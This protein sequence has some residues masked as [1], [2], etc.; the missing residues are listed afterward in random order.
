[1]RFDFGGRL[2]LALRMG[3]LFMVALGI[4]AACVL[5]RIS[6][7]IWAVPLFV[8]YIGGFVFVF[9][10]G[11]RIVVAA[12]AS[13]TIEGSHELPNDGQPEH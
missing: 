10:H 3:L 11:D 7:W 2:V 6:A 5:F 1:L 12:P 8:A 9:R 4:A 13:C